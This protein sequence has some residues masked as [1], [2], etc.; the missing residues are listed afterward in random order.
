VKTKSTT[1]VR[2]SCLESDITKNLL[3]IYIIHE[4]GREPPLCETLKSSMALCKSMLLISQ[5]SEKLTLPAKRYVKN[6]HIMF[7]QSLE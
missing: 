7:Y 3:S 2:R 1:G 6:C 5:Y 4:E